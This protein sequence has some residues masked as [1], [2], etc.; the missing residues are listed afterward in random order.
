[1]KQWNRISGGKPFYLKGIQSVADAK[2]A[3]EMGVH[4]VVVSNYAG[5]QVDAA[6]ASLD[7]LEKIVDGMP[8]IPSFSY[9]Q[10]LDLPSNPY[11]FNS[12]SSLTSNPISRW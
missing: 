10:F 6:V 4:G 2:K 8:P 11:L 5:R 12:N 7:A 9:F 1:M 3:M